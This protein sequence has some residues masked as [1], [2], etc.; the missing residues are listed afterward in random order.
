VAGVDVAKQEVTEVVEFLKYTQKFVALGV[1]IPKGVL[2]VRPPGAGKAGSARQWE[3]RPLSPSSR[4]AYSNLL[5][6]EALDEAR[7]RMGTGRRPELTRAVV[8]RATSLLERK[9]GR[10]D[11]T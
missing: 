4:R 11:G 5:G 3:M 6:V 2:M 1:R 8:H 7:G 10:A 9:A